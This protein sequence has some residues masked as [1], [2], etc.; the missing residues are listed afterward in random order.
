[1]EVGLD[2]RKLY[3][4]IA[5]NIG[6]GKTTLT[7][8][9]SKK[10]G[11]KAY[12]EN[13]IDNP[14]LDDFYKDMSR[15][16][17]N[18]QVYFLVNR[19]KNQKEISELSSSCI[20]DRSIREDSDVFTYTLYKRGLLEERDYKIYCDLFSSLSSYLREPD[21]V[22]YLKTPVEIL[23]R[24]IRK[25]GKVYEK[26]I[27]ASY[28]QPLNDAYERWIEKSKRDEIPIYTFDMANHDFEHNSEDFEIIYKL[29]CDMEKQL[30][31]ENV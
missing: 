3:V 17:F 20:Q 10:L 23:L 14:Y 7:K 31:I 11:W 8:L 26:K 2:S 25:R 15:W 22:I 5:G 21:L 28:L 12:Y 29:I 1:V 30:W 6:S 16:S 4:V 18:L 24:R 19:F 13:V 27:D 9:L